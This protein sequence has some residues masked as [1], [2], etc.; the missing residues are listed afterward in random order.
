MSDEIKP[1]RVVIYRDGYPNSKKTFD[2]QPA[3][4][5]YAE[6]M[7]LQRA[8]DRKAGKTAHSWHYISERNY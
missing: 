1:F 7:K 3:A 8:T 2:T 4:D 6:Q 5:A